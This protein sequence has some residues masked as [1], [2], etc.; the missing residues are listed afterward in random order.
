MIDN[1]YSY[2]YECVQGSNPPCTSACP[3]NFKTRNFIKKI[4]KGNFNS[5]YKDY[6]QNVI[7]PGIVSLICPQDCIGICPEKISVIELEKAAVRYATR[8]SP[9]N[10][11]L[12]ERQEKIA[13]IGGGLSGMACAHRLATRKYQVT[14]YEKDSELGGSLKDIIDQK[15]LD[16]E[17]T[18][19]FEY[20]NYVL[21]NEEILDLD[22]LNYDAVYIATGEGGNDFGLL[23]SWD[24]ESLATEKAGVFL[25]GRISGCSHMAALMH[26][27]IA[28]ASIEKYIQVGSMSGQP[29][30]YLNTECKIPI[31]EE[32]PTSE[33]VIPSNGEYFSKEEA[34]E[35][36]LRCVLCDCTKCKDRCEFLQHMDLLPRKVESDSQMARSADEGLFERVGTRMI[37]SCSVCGLCG[38]VC[39]KNINVEDIL[40]ESKKYLYES[41]HFPPALHDFYIR[42]MVLA[43]TDAYLA[44]AA[45]G[46]DKASY[47]FFPGCQMTASG[48]EHVEK[49]YS[50]ILSK[51]PDTALLLGCCGV[52]A[53]WA[54]NHK[55]LNE[56]LMQIKKEWL[57]FGKPKIVT[58]CSTCTKTFA[59]YL[60]ELE[61]ISL[62][63]YINNNG[64]PDN[65]DYF[66][67]EWVVFDPCSSRNF[68]QMQDAVRDLSRKLGAELIEIR[69]SKKE[70][71]CCGMGGH[72]YPSNPEV[73]RKMLNASVN[74]SDLPYISYCTNCRNL[75]LSAGKNTRHILDGVFGL[76]PLKKPFHISELRKNRLK[77]KKK[78]LKNIWGENFEIMEKKYMVKLKISEEVYDKMDRLHISEEDVYQVAEHCQESN[79]TIY[80]KETKIYTG[81]LQI[82]IITYWIQYKKHDEFLEITNVYS[83]RIMIS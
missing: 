6:A 54:G 10:Y 4:Q 58:V 62:Y 2:T 65:S 60:P 17:F 66:A 42:D 39:P 80:N 7:F 44:K 51:N 57:N 36:A 50:Y 53:L 83:H 24:S 5:A 22:K 64:M 9:I 56:V 48:T 82:G 31:K 45:P 13:I 71:R 21:I 78:M 19:Q 14:L 29:E 47:M 28:A 76:E 63:E 40:I 41:G 25:G 72:I 81:H 38:S 67:G 52:P 27:M 73:F 34:V 33:S 11:N 18:L 1:S 43:L 8:K 30:T 3:I 59:E 26:G 69:D 68:P 20:I 12:P 70:A 32:A 75:F 74:S 55:L 23:S 61:V 49:A 37:V 46:F 15:I 35:E 79:K 77:L 16:D